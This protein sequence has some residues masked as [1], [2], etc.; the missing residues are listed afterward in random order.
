MRSHIRLTRWL[1]TLVRGKPDIPYAEL[2]GLLAL[3]LSQQARALARTTDSGELI[4]LAD[5]DRSKWDKTLIQEAQV[6]TEKSLAMGKVGPYQIQA[7]ISA[8]HNQAKKHRHSLGCW[9][10]FLLMAS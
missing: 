6:L 4:L 7:A 8:L 9:V 10:L 1:H 5:Q 2:L 3:M